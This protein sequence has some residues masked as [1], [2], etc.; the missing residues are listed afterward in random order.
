MTAVDGARLA[1]YPST[2][3]ALTLAEADCEVGALWMLDGGSDAGD[4]RHAVRSAS[5]SLNRALWAAYR[6]GHTPEEIRQKIPLARELYRSCSFVRR[7][8]EWPRGYKGDFETIKCVMELENPYLTMDIRHH[9]QHY[10]LET[11]LSQQHR[12][13]VKAQSK[14]V[15]SEMLA[16]KSSVVLSIACGGCPDFEYFIDS[17]PNDG[18][19][20]VLNDQD[21]DATARSRDV[22]LNSEHKPTIIEGNIFRRFKPISENGPYDLILAGGLF[23][24]LTP[25]AARLLIEKILRNMLR[26]GGKLF[27]TNVKAENPYEPWMECVADWPLLA[28]SED[29]ILELT[30]GLGSI[31]TSIK[32]EETGLS[33]LVTIRS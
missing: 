13:K 5:Y 21:P 20:I 19:R 1:L 7:I 28:R 17:M 2:N 4:I 23:D 10:I 32:Y 30:R 24:Y 15:L 29:D 22:F 9:V 16:N 12:N 31:T 8:S 25:R 11:P 3:S 27:F 6:A 26:P 18:Q 33:L 14:I